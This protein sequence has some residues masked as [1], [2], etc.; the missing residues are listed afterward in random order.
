MLKGL[1]KIEL[2]KIIRKYMIDHFS[3]IC[4]DLTL[5]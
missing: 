5:L 4:N 3:S 1:L 2:L